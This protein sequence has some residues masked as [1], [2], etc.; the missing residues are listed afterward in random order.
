MAFR[1]SVLQEDDIACVVLRSDVSDYSDSEILNSDSDVTTT[2]SHKQLPSSAVVI[3]SD[4]ETR[5][6][7]KE[8]SAPE[9]CDD[10][11]NDMWCKT[12]KKTKQLAFPRNHRSDY[13]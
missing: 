1:R 13:S 8:S 12:V 7:E 3:T 5:A 11:I 4:S 9:S 2:S 6:V 10:K